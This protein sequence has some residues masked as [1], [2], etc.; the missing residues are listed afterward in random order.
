[1]C[2][3]DLSYRYC[4]MFVVFCTVNLYILRIYDLFHILPSLLHSYG[5]M[6]CMYAHVCVC[7]CVCVCVRLYVCKY[8]Q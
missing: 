8:V 1:M 6:E 5:S 2:K 4:K 7:V 3:D